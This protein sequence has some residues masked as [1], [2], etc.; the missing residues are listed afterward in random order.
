MKSALR[1]ALVALP[2]LPF[3][4]VVPVTLH[5]D[6]KANAPADAPPRRICRR[7]GWK[8]L[9]EVRGLFMR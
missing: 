1:V 3:L 9:A 2:P 8:A 6:S 5:A 4:A 7:L